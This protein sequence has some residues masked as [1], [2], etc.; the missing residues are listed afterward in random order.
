MQSLAFIKQ[1]RILV[2]KIEKQQLAVGSSTE[3]RE[4]AKSEIQK[5]LNQLFS[6]LQNPTLPSASKLKDLATAAGFTIPQRAASTIQQ[7]EA[8]WN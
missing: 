8:Y 5:E 2:S 4:Q 3:D 7:A 1:A 6:G